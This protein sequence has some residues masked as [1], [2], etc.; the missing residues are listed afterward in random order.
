MLSPE[1]AVPESVVVEAGF[2]WIVLLLTPVFQLKDAAL[3]Q[4]AVN[5]TV[6]PSH[7][8]SGPAITIT[9]DDKVE[10]KWFVEAEHPL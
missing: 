3:A 8:S 7:M 9:G 5:E 4:T 1:T 2:T 6:S 10:T